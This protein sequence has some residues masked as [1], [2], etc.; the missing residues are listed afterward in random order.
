MKYTTMALTFAS[1]AQAQ[2]LQQ[3]VD[4]TSGF[5]NGF[6]KSSIGSDIST[7][8]EVLEGTYQPSGPCG[9]NDIENLMQDALNI[10]QTYENTQCESFPNATPAPVCPSLL[11]AT[12]SYNFLT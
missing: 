12:Q 8:Y 1:N 11:D 3:A 9:S 2:T 7:S 10:Y 6:G 4:L 5:F